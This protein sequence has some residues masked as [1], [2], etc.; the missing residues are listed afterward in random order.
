MPKY[1]CKEQYDVFQ[2]KGDK[3]KIFAWWDRF[4]GTVRDTLVWDNDFLAGS[5]K[6]IDSIGFTNTVPY[7]SYLMMDSCSRLTVLPE[8]IFE[9]RYERI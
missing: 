8:Q 6:V 5:L 7:G 4:E 1:R 2:W 9:M 3:D